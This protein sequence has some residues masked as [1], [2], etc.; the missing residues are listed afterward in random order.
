MI[1]GSKI[2][3]RSGIAD[4]VLQTPSKTETAFNQLCEALRA[5]I[6]EMRKAGQERFHYFGQPETAR[7]LL[8]WAEQRVRILEQVELV[9]AQWRMVVPL[10]PP[11]RLKGHPEPTA[12]ERKSA[13]LIRNREGVSIDV[14]AQCLGLSKKKVQ[15]CLEDGSLKGFRPASGR[16]KIPRSEVSAFAKRRL[17]SPSAKPVE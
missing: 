3:S 13:V 6:E 4:A 16:W 2:R 17:P 8:H 5:E 11:A 1:T 14:A 12:A 9:L 7:P 10:P 15:E